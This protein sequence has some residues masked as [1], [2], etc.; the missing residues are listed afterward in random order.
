MRK[1]RKPATNQDIAR[2]LSE[3]SDYL[4]M[5]DEPFRPL[6][7]GR[8][9]RAVQEIEEPVT[10]IYKEGGIKALLE[11]PG[12]GASIAE[13]IA[14]LIDTGRIAYYEELKRAAPIQMSDMTRIEGVGPK[15]VRK[16]YEELGV[17]TLTDLERA[18]KAGK[19]RAIP[20][21]G[22]KTEENILKGISFVKKT[23]GR[24]VLGLIEKD[25]VELAERLR[26]E[27]TVREVTIAGSIRRRKET[28]GDADILAVADNPE[29]LMASFVSQPEVTH[30]YAHG[31]TRSSVKLVS[32]IDVDLRIVPRKSYGAAMNYF[33]GSKEHN[34]ALRTR[35]IQRGYKLNEYG[36][37]K[38]LAGDKEG[39]R[40]AGD[41]EEELYRALG[42][43]YIPPELREARGEIEA[44]EAGRLP[45]L[46]PYDS[47]RGD[48]QVQTSWSDGEH[49]IIEMARAAYERGLQYMAVT[50]H[51]KRL[52]M[53]HGLD[54]RRLKHQGKEID[55]AN[56]FL[57]GEGID[58]TILKSTEC[59]VLRDGTLDLSDEALASLDLVGIAVHSHFH[60]S[61]REQTER[62]VR[63]MR[64]PN[65]DIVFHPTGRVLNKR[66]AYEVDMERIIAVAKETGVVLEIDAYPDRLDLDDL[67][68]RR[69]VEEGVLL[70]I[71]SDAHHASHFDYLAYGIGQAR[72]GWVEAKNVINTRPL[73]DMLKLLRRNR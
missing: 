39:K 52:A 17:K 51:T 67:A 54:E 66:E 60:L 33:T 37:F 10:G 6:A 23:G 13:K 71:D 49:S 29:A 57:A 59:D 46:I 63:A 3:I 36:L 61:R 55:D 73:R 69:C 5:E 9:A 45:T 34:V 4:A 65:V 8:A 32:G 1:V 42:M 7:Y 16:L 30:V 47:L 15:T 21:F 48:L 20:G 44:A 22:E 25:V 31:E 62:I 11:I 64:N 35:A 68:A 50:D 26:K 14:E 18:A 38:R 24:F 12:V 43:D 41:N 58:F 28:I 53:T 72:R 27:K 40:V 2:T 56:R 70:V 19:I